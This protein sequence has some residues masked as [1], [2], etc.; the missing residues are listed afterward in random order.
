M[1]SSYFSATD[2]FYYRNIEIPQ[3]VEKTFNGNIFDET[4]V[5]KE[6]QKT[7]VSM[8][9]PVKKYQIKEGDTFWNLA[10][11]FNLNID[12]IVSYNQPKKVHV[13]FPGKI[14]DIPE[15][16]GILVERKKQ[17]LNDLALRYKVN[18]ETITFFNPNHQIAKYL[19]IPG[20]Y[21]GLAERMKKLGAEFFT[22][23][24]YFRITSLFGPRI[25]PITKRRAFH[26]GIDLAAPKSSPVFAAKGGRVLYAGPSPGFGK[27]ITIRH[28]KGYVT[29]YGHLSQIL[30]KTGRQIAVQQIIGRVGNT[31]RSTG[32]HLHFEIW[33][34]NRPIDPRDVTDFRKSK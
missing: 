20:A 34:K 8:N 29:R 31:G 18:L 27:L 7:N 11:K 26:K 9:L 6:Y 33:L 24:K 2:K 3:F 22:P 12:T 32:Y 16:N 25:H 10:K 5:V 14:I 4:L 30:V 28:S 13:I 23:L 17:S 21:Y 19:F 15:K 1:Y